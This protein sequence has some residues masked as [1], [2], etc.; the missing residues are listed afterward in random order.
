MTQPYLS[1][2]RQLFCLGPMALAVLTSTARATPNCFAD[3]SFGA[4]FR[5][6]AFPLADSLAAAIAVPS[7]AGLFAACLRGGSVTRLRLSAMPSVQAPNEA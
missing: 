3:E 7:P 5:G 6:V 1:A 2:S 4:R